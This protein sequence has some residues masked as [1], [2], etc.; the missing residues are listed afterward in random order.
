MKVTELSIPGVLL[1]EPRVF[2][3]ARGF[4]VETWQRER[5]A[6]AGLKDSFVQDNLSRSV[7]GVLRGLHLQ[8]PNAQGKLV[9]VPFGAVIDV[10]VDVR[11]GSPTFGKSVAVELSGDNHHQLWVPRGCAHGFCVTS[12]WALF[13]YKCDNAYSPKDE[14]SVRFDDPDLGISW[15]ALQYS[16]SPKD[17]AAKRLCEIDPALLPKYA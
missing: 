11:V 13:S 2:G 7:R 3:D 4:F 12:E 17:Q 14:M 8:H 5:Y 15:P 10:A 1:I 6:E 16:L 9:S